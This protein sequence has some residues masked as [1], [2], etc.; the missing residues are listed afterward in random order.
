M[1]IAREKTHLSG[2]WAAVAIFFGFMLLHQVDRLLVGPLTDDILTT[3]NINYAQMGLVT[4]GALI[5]GTLLYPVWGWLYDRYSRAKLLSLASLI[6]GSTTWLAAIAPTY[7][8]FV[9][10]RASTG[11]DDSSYP[12]IYSL[13]G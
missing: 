5:V 8:A 4:T 1:T 9:A 12:G 7:P 6:W 13:I 2:R 11:I 3:F 10:A